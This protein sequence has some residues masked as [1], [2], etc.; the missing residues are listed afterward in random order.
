MAWKRFIAA[1]DVHGDMQ[2]KEAV[3][4]FFEFLENHWKPH[5][6]IMGGDLF[7][8]RAMRNGAS[9]EEKADG[10][11]ADYQQGMEFLN[12]FQPTVFLRGNHDERLWDWASRT[13]GSGLII[14]YCLHGVREIEKDCRA[15]RCKMLPYDKR[16]GVYRLG[17]MHVVHGFRSGI[18]AAKQTCMDYGAPTLMGHIHAV[19]RWS[20]PGLDRRAG[21][22]S[23]ALCQI[24]MPYNARQAN[25]LRQS[26]GFAYGEFND[27]TGKFNVNLAERIDGE[28]FLYEKPLKLR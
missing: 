5:V 13:Q 25:T 3:R 21:W 16:H 18:T 11:T 1:F 10:I 15:M 7:D 19:D 8:F 4:V 24:D 26:N 6:K 27:K 17:S 9:E 2:D 22:S 28:W 23:G 12:R 14:D 20:A